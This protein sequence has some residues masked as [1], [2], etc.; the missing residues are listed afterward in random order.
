MIPPL[1]LTGGTSTATAG[2]QG[3]EIYAPYTAGTNTPSLM[4][5]VMVGVV[6]IA[7]VMLVRR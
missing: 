2:V 5:M 6:V 1:N 7:L 4:Q 3:S